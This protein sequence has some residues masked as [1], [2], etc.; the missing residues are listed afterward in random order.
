MS[1]SWARRG[2]I[3]L[4]I[5]A[6]GAIAWVVGSLALE[7]ADARQASRFAGAAALGL[8]LLGAWL[9]GLLARSFN[10]PSVSG[11][12]LFGLTAG[13]GALGLITQPQLDM[14]KF[15]NEL[16]ISLIALTAGGEI[17]WRF[18]RGEAR[19]IALTTLMQTLIIGVGAAAL[20]LIALPAL[21]LVPAGLE[22]AELIRAAVLVGVISVASSPAVVVAVT[23]ELRARSAFTRRAISIAICKDL[24][25][26]VIFAI[27]ISIAAAPTSRAHGESAPETS[28]V[29][30]T[31]V[32]S[33]SSSSAQSE[34]P[35]RDSAG[36]AESGGA[37]GVLGDVSRR[38]FGSLAAG[39]V[40]GL[41][42]AWY[43]H[44]LRVN[45]PVFVVLA[46]FGIAIGAEAFGLEP[47]IVALVAGMLMENVFGEISEALF[48][49][50]E[51]LSLPVF[52]V[53]FATAG[54]RVAPANLLVS[55]PAALVLVGARGG[56]IWLATLAG[57]KAAGLSPREARGLW[58][59]FIPQ[60]GVSLALLTIVREKLGGR[61]DVQALDATIL[62]AITMHAV[63]GPVLFR[64]AVVRAERSAASEDQPEAGAATSSEA[65]Q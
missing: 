41:L 32:D 44:T 51:D 61:F 4:A 37:G 42:L 38:I 18:L 58:T 63:V 56:L 8:L 45:L 49:A 26:V 19:L 64:R 5:L 3:A 16:A 55:G 27:A 57:S 6:L 47:L 20:A 40:I 39:V 52:C 1:G 46:G 24:T 48:D 25:L 2:R 15:A 53:F 12:L 7:H 54:A 43:M 9:S 21:G 11:F 62:A 59:A 22:R 10:L 35:S 34:R 36:A 29:S 60:A 13:P 17:R 31:Q 30:A 14:L 28:A 65:R 23:S 50:I 33:D